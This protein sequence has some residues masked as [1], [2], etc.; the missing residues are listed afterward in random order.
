MTRRSKTAWQQATNPDP[1]NAAPKPALF[2]ALQA[3]KVRAPEPAVHRP[4]SASLGIAPK[5]IPAIADLEQ[6]MK[7]GGFM[8]A[9]TFFLAMARAQGR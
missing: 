6:S 9:A 3:V 1:A 4:H 5:T 7:L 8:R 2:S